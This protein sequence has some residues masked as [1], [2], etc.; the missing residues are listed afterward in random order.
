[1][2]KGGDVSHTRGASGTPAP[3]TDARV[4]VALYHLPSINGDVDQR[5]DE[6]HYGPKAYDVRLGPQLGVSTLTEKG[7]AGPALTRVPC[8]RVPRACVR[9]SCHARSLGRW[10]KRKAM[11]LVIQKYARRFLASKLFRASRKAARAIQHRRRS[12]LVWVEYRKRHLAW[13]AKRER[14]EA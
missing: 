11:Q 13:L 12:Q 6:V 14:E 5:V 3:P 10:E 4:N 9:A 7:A 2:A 1:M 8:S